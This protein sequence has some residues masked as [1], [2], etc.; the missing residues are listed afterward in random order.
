[1]NGRQIWI[2][3]LNVLQCQ[4]TALDS[5]RGAGHGKWTRKRKT[6][7]VFS[8]LA[9]PCTLRVCLQIQQSLPGWVALKTALDADCKV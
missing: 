3:N 4:A 9:F 6:I 1:M 2:S 8:L 7:V 5:L